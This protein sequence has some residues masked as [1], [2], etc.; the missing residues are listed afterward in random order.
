MGQTGVSRA[1]IPVDGGGAGTR[2]LGVLPTW[3]PRAD[4][5]RLRPMALTVL[6]IDDHAGFRAI[7]RTILEAAG[8]DVV[9][10]AADGESGLAAAARTMPDLALVDIQLPDIDGFEVTRRLLA[11]GPNPAIVLVSS[12]DCSDFGSLVESSGANGFV[13]KA[14]ISAESLAAVL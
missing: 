5:R 4:L 7:A 9:A 14:E 11:A 12:R 8:Y 10:E 2:T 13:P 6:V 1:C 3:D